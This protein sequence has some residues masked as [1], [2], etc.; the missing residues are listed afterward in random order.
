[1]H[2]ARK[3]KEAHREPKERKRVNYTS[4]AINELYELKIKRKTKRDRLNYL[5]LA[6][7]LKPTKKLNRN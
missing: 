3:Q 6:E 4:K 1:M 2:T 7:M 5:L